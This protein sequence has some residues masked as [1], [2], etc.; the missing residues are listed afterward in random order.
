MSGFSLFLIVVVFD[1]YYLHPL[2]YYE[3]AKKVIFPFLFHLLVRVFTRK[4]FPPLLSICY[5]KVQA[6]QV[7]LVVKNPRAN[8]GDVRD[9]G[10]GHGNPLQFLAWES[11]GQRSLV[12]YSQSLGSQRVRYD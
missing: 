5:P 1:N 3:F 8:A 4:E 9:P 11:H 12:V 7:V 6:S 10:G 2:F